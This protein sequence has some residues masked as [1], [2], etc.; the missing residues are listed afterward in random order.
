MLYLKEAR[1]CQQLCQLLGTPDEH[2]L[3]YY[4]GLDGEVTSRNLASHHLHH[5][6]CFWVLF[7]MKYL[8]TNIMLEAQRWPR[9]ENLLAKK[10]DNPF[11]TIEWVN[12]KEN[13]NS[14]DIT[15][16]LTNKNSKLAHSL[17]QK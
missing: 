2:S 12:R 17:P 7:N 6:L 9:R 3:K 4:K 8:L 14:D 10:G 13:E 11:Q 1:K 16:I 5:G 15:L